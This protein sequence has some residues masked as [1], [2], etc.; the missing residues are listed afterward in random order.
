LETYKKIVLIFAFLF[1]IISCKSPVI[2]DNKEQLTIREKIFNSSFEV[3]GIAKNDTI[4]KEIFVWD[5]IIKRLNNFDTI[6]TT[7]NELTKYQTIKLVAM[8]DTLRDTIY[9]KSETKIE[10]KDVIKYVKVV[11]KW[12]WW[13]IFIAI[14]EFLII[15][16]YLKFK[17]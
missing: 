13:F 11:P 17:K 6:S 2:I 16:L 9:K 4:K 8:T 10:Y 1:F 7:F 14:A 5:T 3:S 12:L 15:V